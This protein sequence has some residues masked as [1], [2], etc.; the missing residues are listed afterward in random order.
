[1]TNPSQ[2]ILKRPTT[3][4]LFADRMVR[5]GRKE[6]LLA[7]SKKLREEKGLPSA[8]A[9]WSAMRIMGYVDAETERIIHERHEREQRA[10]EEEA[11]QTAAETKSFN[12][13]METLPD[14]CSE[15]EGIAWLR[16]HPAM[17]RL[18]RASDKT[19]PILID[20]DDLL[21]PSHGAAPSKAWANALQHW[22]N[23]P[24]EFFK[25]S[26]SESKKKTGE[27]EETA[28]EEVE[29]DLAEVE[30]LLKSVRAGKGD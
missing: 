13:A 15:A 3:R 26:L 10:T 19:K 7:L 20:G 8:A 22:A 21:N 4:R 17:S 27:K 28:S 12:E 6:E 25:Q 24:G 16:A 11:V 18:D 29:D 1:M 9:S 2:N 23:R 30:K 5:E 14:N